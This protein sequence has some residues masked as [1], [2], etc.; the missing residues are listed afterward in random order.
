MSKKVTLMIFLGVLFCISSIS[1]AEGRITG[2]VLMEYFNDV[3]GTTTDDL[4]SSSKYGNW[5]PD[6]QIWLTTFDIPR[7]VGDN[8][9]A[10]ISGYLLPPETGDYTFYICSDDSSDLSL[11]T[12]ES[13]ED[14]T[15]ICYMEGWAGPGSW[16]KYETQ[17][18]ASVSLVA[19]QAYYIQA[20]YKEG[21]GGDNC[22]VAWKGPG[23][24]DGN[25]ITVI[26]GQYLSPYL[27]DG[28]NDPLI[29]QF[30]K[31]LVISPEDGGLAGNAEPTLAWS[32]NIYADH[33]LLYLSEDFDE[34]NDAAV[35]AIE[36]DATSYIARGLTAQSTYYWRVD[37]VGSDETLYTGN[38][39]SFTIAP[40]YATQPSPPDG[41]YFM[42]PNI[43]L[44]WT[45]GLNAIEHHLYFGSN[46]DDVA[47]GSNG[48]DIG[49]M[50]EA[51]Y[52]LDTLEKGVTYYWRVD[53]NDGSETF[54]G[55]VWQFQVEYDDIPLAA[56]ANLV[57]WWKLNEGTY[58]RVVDW[59][60]HG[61]DGTIVGDPECVEGPEG[62]AISFSGNDDYIEMY[63]CNAFD[64]GIDGDKPRTICGWMYTRTVNTDGGA[65]WSVGNTDKYGDFALIGRSNGKWRLNHWYADLDFEMETEGEWIHLTQTYDGSIE[66]VYRNGE[67]VIT[68]E[69]DLDTT[70]GRNFKIGD[71]R[72]QRIDGI[73]DDVR[74][75]TMCADEVFIT[76]IMRTNLLQAWSPSPSPDAEVD[77]EQA[78]SLSFAAGDNAVEHDIYFGSDA[79]VVEAADVNSSEYLGRQVETVVDTSSQVA[80]GETYYWRVDEVDVN[81]LVTAGK[82]WS[83]NVVDYL[84]IDDFESYDDVN[85]PVFLTW[86]DGYDDDAG[87]GTGGT[88]GYTNLPY[89]ETSTVHGGNQAV[90]FKYYNNKSM[91]EDYSEISL[92]YDSA[93]DFTRMG[94]THLQLSFYGHE[95]NDA[96][97]F[98]VALEDA[99]GQVAEVIY[100]DNTA[101]QTAEWQDWTIA[102]S[103]FAGI[104]LQA[105]KTLYMGTGDRNN[106]V[107]GG[108][109]T[110][111]LDDII[112]TVAP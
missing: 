75:Y 42:D 71:Y 102:L 107:A 53:E 96:E 91:R 48:T 87:N 8:Y 104:D 11:S 61:F 1:W 47:A 46:A 18:S 49:V 24:A 73:M 15:Q 33:Y 103:D 65:P 101:L 112:L 36:V 59:S 34:V 99:S 64:L 52:E 66:R 4:R 88:I 100:A 89:M 10:V 5:T 7:N 74:V 39:W 23:I 63:D 105:V 21:S 32:E 106:P 67:L 85:N 30:Y 26:D 51:S 72:D 44:S 93:Q 9:G 6:E 60:G 14:S 38:V 98:Y 57:G 95:D 54:T 80:M 17:T 83:L 31:A 68:F 69:V 2:Y 108:A 50:T 19:G 86:L 56:D 58:G 70:G 29:A 81:G 27:Y 37:G 79:S 62:L 90:P 3:S 43:D 92:T 40:K 28:D 111:I 84:I 109:G 82:V 110:M 22:Q 12:N 77:V 76:Q 97:R 45:I 78:G 94:I 35:E 20:D 13:Y 25:T 41:V 16:T 55:D